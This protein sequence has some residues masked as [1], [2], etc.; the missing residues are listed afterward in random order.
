[1]GRA[2]KKLSLTTWI[3]IALVAG[4]AFGTLLPGP[5]TKFAVLGDIFLRLIAS[6]L[7]PLMFATLVVGVARSGSAKTMGR[8]GGKALLLFQVLTTIALLIGVGTAL[9][10]KPGIGIS[11]HGGDLASVPQAATNI[12]QIL[13]SPFPTS[14]IDAMARGDVLQIVVFAVLFGF[15]CASIG[16]AAAPVVAFCESLSEIMFR[17]THYVMFTAPFG[18]FGAVAASVG[19]KGPEVLFSLGKLVLAVYVGLIVFVLLVLWPLAIF[20]RVPMRRF[21]TLVREPFMIAFSTT[22]SNVALPQALQNME[23]LGVPQ[24]IAA[25]VLP[26]SMSFNTTGSCLFVGLAAVFGAQAAGVVLPTGTLVLMVLTLMLTTKGIG[27]VPRGSLVI[28]TGALTSFGLPLEGVAMI[29]G[30]DQL[31]DMAR[32]SVN[33]LGHCLATAVVARWEGA[34]LEAGV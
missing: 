13:V 28:L 1:V 19:S 18:I 12:D 22:S 33:M 10:M 7:A 2:L 8:V 16:A 5:A 3:F 11:G 21:L 25:L 23:E 29:L 4:M 15:A 9:L 14:I 6:I 32:T 17:Y 20:A 30:V 31:M 24:H 26:S 34:K 27:A